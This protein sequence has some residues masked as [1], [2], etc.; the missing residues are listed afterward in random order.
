[1][2]VLWISWIVLCSE[3]NCRIKLPNIVNYVG[4]FLFLIGV[5]FFLAALLTIKTLETYDGA[6]ITSGIYSKIRHPMYL[7]FVLWLIGSPIFFGSVFSFILSL[8]FISNV[9][10]WR[11][12]EELELDKRF[13]EYKL[14]KTQT[15]F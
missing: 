7:G 12:L 6:L 13:P 2:G 5:I 8:L 10:F 9:L 3:D 1:M 14:Y 11:Y 15:I 4:F